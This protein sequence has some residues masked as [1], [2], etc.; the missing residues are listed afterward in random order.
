MPSGVRTSTAWAIVKTRPTTA[1]ELLE[2]H[3]LGP[4][5]IAKFGEAILTL[6]ARAAEDP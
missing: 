1:A 3:G 6:V 2:I 5:R 4:T